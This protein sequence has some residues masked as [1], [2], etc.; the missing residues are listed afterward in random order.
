MKSPATGT[1]WIWTDT[2]F[3]GTP[4]CFAFAKLVW[5][6][7]AHFSL[8]PIFCAVRDVGT[9]VGPSLS[10]RKSEFLEMFMTERRSGNNASKFGIYEI[11]CCVTILKA[12]KLLIMELY[13]IIFSLAHW[14]GKAAPSLGRITKIGQAMFCILNMLHCS[15]KI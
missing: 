3:K 4:G 6:L 9:T 7:P 13:E 11:L 1:F 15:V 5:F 10:G 8:I 2:P 12:I 14:P